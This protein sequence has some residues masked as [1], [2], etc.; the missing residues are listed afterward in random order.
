[1]VVSEKVFRYKNMETVGCLQ[2][3]YLHCSFVVR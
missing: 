3:G 1:M 2:V